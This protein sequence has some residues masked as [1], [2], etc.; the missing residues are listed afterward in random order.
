MPFLLSLGAA[1]I[2]STEEVECLPSMHKSWF[3]DPE[4]KI[5]VV[6]IVIVVVVIIIT[7]SMNICQF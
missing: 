3:P 5:V 7:A 2:G 6:I 4:E 1:S